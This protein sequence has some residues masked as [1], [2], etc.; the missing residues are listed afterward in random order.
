MTALVRLERFTPEG[1]AL[2]DCLRVRRKLG[3]PGWFR[4]T[5]YR[6]WLGLGEAILFPFCTR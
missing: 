4:S 6:G 5:G 2:L 3:R 1:E